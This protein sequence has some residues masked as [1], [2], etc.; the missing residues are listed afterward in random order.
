MGILTKVSAQDILVVEPGVGTL[1]AAVATNGGDKIYQ[2]T[3]GEWYGLDAPIENDGYHLQVIGSEPATEGGKPATLQTGSDVDGN[4]FAMMFNGKGDITLKNIYFVNADLLGQTA[5]GFVVQAAENGRVTVDGCVLHPAAVVVAIQGVA[6]NTKTYFTNNLAVNHGHQA[7]PNDGWFFHY[8]AAPTAGPDTVLIENNTFVAMGMCMFEVGFDK[9]NASTNYVN[10][11][12]N[13]FVMTKSQIDWSYVE[14]EYYWTNNL[15]FD[16]QTQPYFNHWQPMPGNDGSYPKPNLVYSDTLA[17]ESLP[18]SRPCFVQ[19]NSHYRAQGFY[20]FIDDEVNVYAADSSLPGAY[21]FDLTWPVDT[22]NSGEVQMFN[23]DDFPGYKYGNTI[24]NVD[25][26]WND[27]KIYEHEAN[28][29]EWTKPAT[30]IHGFGLPADN[31]PPASE[32]PKFHWTPSGDISDNSVWPLFD[33][34]YTDDA[35]LKGS[36]EVNVPL[37][38]LNWYPAAKAAWMENK[39]AIDAH[40]KAG[41][42]EQI[43]IGYDPTVSVDMQMLKSFVMYPNPANDVLYFDMDAAAEITIFAI[44]GRTLKSEVNVSRMDISDLAAGTYIVNVKSAS[45]VSSQILI[46]E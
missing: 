31:Y 30:W 6:D 43:D 40:I 29:I 20:D 41:N 39:A 38:D 19:Y 18:S 2:L 36:I 11:N 24:K 3:A 34:T 46:K 4:P 15:M 13:T 26:K 28:F 35:T 44:D 12:H 33:G 42:T 1:N 9:F 25:P 5:N 17:G 8:G 14:K 22:V 45:A 27:A 16:V 7:S 32:W 10:W 37:G 21:L 23:S